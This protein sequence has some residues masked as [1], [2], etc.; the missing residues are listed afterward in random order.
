MEF[1]EADFIGGER[2]SQTMNRLEELNKIM[3]T[4][5]DKWNASPELR[6]EHFKLTS[7]KIERDTRMGKN[8]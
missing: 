4:D 5:I 2:G 1:G 7:A 6:A 3:K 8:Q